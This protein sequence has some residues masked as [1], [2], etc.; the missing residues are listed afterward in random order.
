[1]IA[2]TVGRKYGGTTQA[3]EIGLPVENSP[4]ILPCGSTG[5]WIG[6]L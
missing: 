3:D 4:Y 1:M 6:D 5:R 2:M